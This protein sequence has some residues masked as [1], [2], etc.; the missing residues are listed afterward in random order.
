MDNP[1]TGGEDDLIKS[2]ATIDALF[3]ESVIIRFYEFVKKTKVTDIEYH[4]S[5]TKEIERY[6]DLN[7]PRWIYSPILR[8]NPDSRYIVFLMHYFDR[9]PGMQMTINSK[10][11]A[12][13]LRQ[14]EEL[15]KSFKLGC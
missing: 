5:M 8:S 1:L 9:N 3:P 2:Y 6:I 11:S 7:S 10:L 12:S 15:K 13:T 14:I 4:S